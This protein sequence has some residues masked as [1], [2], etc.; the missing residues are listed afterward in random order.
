[1]PVPAHGARNLL[2]TYPGL[3][4]DEALTP[5]SLARIAH[6]SRQHMQQQLEHII[7]ENRRAA[8]RKGWPIFYSVYHPRFDAS[9][10]GGGIG[11][12]ESPDG[13]EQVLAH[14]LEAAA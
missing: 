2:V 5:A 11:L 1:M 3:R 7:R 12:P 14:P 10:P 8:E 13:G 6:M 9:K 4:C